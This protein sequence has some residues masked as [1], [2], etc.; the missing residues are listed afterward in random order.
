MGARAPA[1]KLVVEGRRILAEEA[2]APMPHILQMEP[3]AELMGAELEQEDP[4]L[5]QVPLAS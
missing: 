4:L 1:S 3:P 5:G 2:Q